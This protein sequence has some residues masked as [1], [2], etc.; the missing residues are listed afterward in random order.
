M[1]FA[2]PFAVSADDAPHPST[3]S[4]TVGP[5]HTT[6]S[7]AVNVDFLHARIGALLLLPVV[8]SGDN[9]VNR[10]SLHKS[11]IFKNERK[12]VESICGIFNFCKNFSVL[13]CGVPPALP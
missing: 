5:V 3:R 9:M 6:R 7:A 1:K 11:W 12:R 13:D 4:V 2:R 10:Y 8:S